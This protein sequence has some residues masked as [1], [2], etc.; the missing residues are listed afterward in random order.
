MKKNKNA[1]Q[2]DMPKKSYQQEI[3]PDVKEK[4]NGKKVV[5]GISIFIALFFLVLLIW[6][7]SDTSVKEETYDVEGQTTDVVLQQGEES[8]DDIIIVEQSLLDLTKETVEI[9]IPLDLYRGEIPADSLDETQIANG[10][11]AV[12]KDDTNLVYT[13][14]TS[15]YPSIIENLYSYYDAI[16]DEYEKK[17]SVQLVSS[18]KYCDT[19]TITVEKPGYKANNHYKMLES[20]Y[21]NAAIYQ[22]YLGVDSPYVNFNMKYLHEQTP[23]FGYQFPNSLGKDLSVVTTTTTTQATDSAE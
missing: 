23:F 22:C 6:Y 3:D 10:Y 21:Y 18:N 20:L 19:F 2:D 17:N 7:I 4:D 8:V 16:A 13:I 14:K 5:I 1:P 15:Y 12:K 9:T 11:L